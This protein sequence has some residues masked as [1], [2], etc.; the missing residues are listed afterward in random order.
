MS[1]TNHK[2][3]FQDLRTAAEQQLETGLHP[4]LPVLETPEALR[5]ELSVHQIE[6][7]VQNEELQRTLGQLRQAHQRYVGLYDFAPLGYFTLS[8]EGTIREANLR[9]G[10]LLGVERSRLVGRRLAQFTAPESR[11]ALAVL[12]PRLLVSG[13]GLVAELRLQ[14]ADGSTFPVRLEGQLDLQGGSLIAVTDIT[15]EKT[16]QEEM[17]RLNETLE[18]RVMERTTKIR[19]LGDELRAVALA[20]AEDMT[21]PLHRITSLVELLRRES[22]SADTTSADTAVSRHFDPV[23]RS[24]HRVQDLAQALLEYSRASQMRV[25]FVPLNLNRVLNEVIKDLRP[26]MEGRTVELSSGSLPTV[27]ADIGVMQLVFLKLLE[28]ALK[29][30]STRETAKISVSAE[31]TEGEFILRF[32]DNGV[33]FNNRHKG[34]LFGV[35]QRLHP[36]S[37]FSGAGIGLAIVRRTCTR[38]GGRVWAEGR[39]GEGATFFV[40]WPKQPTMLE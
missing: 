36:E 14:R 39:L 10:R 7:E 24:V 2:K 26:Q 35:F 3:G 11:S 5:H 18:A 22:D 21:A 40:A 33:G 30:T 9:A 25:R 37:A 29:F 38:F 20:V 19:E 12:L 15:T 1:D 13:D 27:S 34:R 17:L 32:S 28:N 31:E 4:A 16:V 8:R 6:L 23:L